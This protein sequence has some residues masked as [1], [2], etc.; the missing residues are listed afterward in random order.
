MLTGR[1]TL[2]RGDVAALPFAD[3]QFDKVLSIHTFYFW[4]NPQQILQDIFRVLKPKGMLVLTL[5]TGR[6]APSGERSYGPLQRTL[7]QQIVPALLGIG[8]ESADLRHGPD[9]R[10]YTSVAV[11]ARR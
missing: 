8:F 1:V 7:E 6:V 10:Q 5:S 4:P 2:L 3:Q 11:I 9:S